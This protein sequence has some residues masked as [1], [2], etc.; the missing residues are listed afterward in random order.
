MFADVSLLV[1]L[2]AFHKMYLSL[3]IF[4]YEPLCVSFGTEVASVVVAE[5]VT[6]AEEVVEMADVAAAVEMVDVAVAVEMVDA[7]AEADVVEA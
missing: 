1:S 4:R 5:D 7:V 3:T 6:E 2:F